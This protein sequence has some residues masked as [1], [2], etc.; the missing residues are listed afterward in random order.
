[1]ISQMPNK[2]LNVIIGKIFN[3]SKNSKNS[4]KGGKIDTK[5][6]VEHN[7]LVSKYIKTLSNNNIYNYLCTKLEKKFS[8]GLE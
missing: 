7:N 1:M 2:I 4:S 5:Y 8:D 3:H 6:I